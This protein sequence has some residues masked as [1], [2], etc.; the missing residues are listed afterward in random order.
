[1]AKEAGMHEALAIQGWEGF[2]VIIG[3]SAGALIGLQFVVLTLIS[4]A[5]RIRGSGET[6]SAFSTPNVV[7]FCA[8]LLISAIMTVPW[9]DLATVGGVLL[10]CGVAGFLY[11]VAVLRRARGQRDYK[12]VLE[13]WIW[14]ITLPLL[15]YG[16]LSLAAI[17]L[18][19]VSWAMFLV[20][21]TAVMLVFIGIHN[22][23]DTVTYVMVDRSQE[24]AGVKSTKPQARPTRSSMATDAGSARAGQQPPPRNPPA[25]AT[26]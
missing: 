9:R 13:D 8:A 19:R 10:L 5:G 22:A 7:H 4:E 23:W 21:A 26:D 25:E 6:V 11:S 24:R 12:P 17:E 14:H 18:S 20:G 16:S 2:Y 15:A 3:T 1:M